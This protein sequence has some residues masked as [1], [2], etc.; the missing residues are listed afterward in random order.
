MKRILIPI[1]LIAFSIAGNA[2]NTAIDQLFD[3]YA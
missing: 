1:L 2:Q 3:R